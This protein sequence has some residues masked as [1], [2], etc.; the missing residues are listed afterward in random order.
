M[1][2]RRWQVRSGRLTAMPF[3]VERLA[4]LEKGREQCGSLP[5][6]FPESWIIE[7]VLTQRHTYP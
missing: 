3:T 7:A 1:P 2:S 5:L 6:T 4:F